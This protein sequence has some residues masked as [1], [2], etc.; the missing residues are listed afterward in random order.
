[1]F[2]PVLI[3]VKIYIYCQ[4]QGNST[5]LC[6]LRSPD[7]CMLVHSFKKI[8]LPPMIVISLFGLYQESSMLQFYIYLLNLE[9]HHIY[10]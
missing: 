10:T 4:H 6:G 9:E 7:I 1:M 5:Q 3:A 2:L 8:T